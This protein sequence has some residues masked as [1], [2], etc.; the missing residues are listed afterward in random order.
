MQIKAQNLANGQWFVERTL[1][2]PHTIVA[3][4]VNNTVVY[5]LPETGTLSEKAS[6]WND[7]T[8]EQAD[9]QTIILLLTKA[10]ADNNQPVDEINQ[11]RAYIKDLTPGQFFRQPTGK[12]GRIFPDGLIVYLNNSSIFWADAKAWAGCEVQIVSLPQIMLS[13]LTDF[14]AF[15]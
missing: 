5:F 11:K 10:C 8:V 1:C 4:K 2:S 15:S 13:L 9:F 3:R 14:Y 12:C 7:I 6:N